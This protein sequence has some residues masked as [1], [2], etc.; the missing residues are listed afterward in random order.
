MHPERLILS[1]DQ[2]ILLESLEGE[3]YPSKAAAADR[4]GVQLRQI[5][6]DCQL[7]RRKLNS[8]KVKRFAVKGQQGL[9]GKSL[10]ALF[11][12]RSLVE[13]KWKRREAAEAVKELILFTG[14]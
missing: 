4:F 7:L 8:R 1:E 14:I 9:D 11:L 6:E 10:Q 5:Q 12:F 13:S 2:R 3:Y